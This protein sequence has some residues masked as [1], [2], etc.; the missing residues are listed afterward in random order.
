MGKD[1][2]AAPVDVGYSD[3]SVG[4][5]WSDTGFLSSD[6]VLGETIVKITCNQSSGTIA[7]GGFSIYWDTAPGSTSWVQSVTI[8][9]GSGNVVL[10]P[11]DP[12]FVVI[13][14]GTH[15]IWTD[16]FSPTWTVTDANTNAVRTITFTFNSPP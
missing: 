16:S 9:T 13:G 5:A 10:S 6:D 11:T 12:D 1:V 7:T 2:G 4:S 15:W 8:S 3:N 14:G